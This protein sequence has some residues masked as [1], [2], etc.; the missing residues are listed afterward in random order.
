MDNFFTQHSE[1][2]GHQGKGEVVF[3][4]S[5]TLLVAFWTFKFHAVANTNYDYF[6]RNE[7]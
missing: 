1:F 6:C 5:L 7:K 3:N 2:T 4:S